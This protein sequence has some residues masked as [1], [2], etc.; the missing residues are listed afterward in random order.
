MCYLHSDKT[1]GSECKRYLTL[2]GSWRVACYSFD[3]KH[4]R[5]FLGSQTLGTYSVDMYGPFSRN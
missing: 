4:A 3:L 5:S 2:A 1:L